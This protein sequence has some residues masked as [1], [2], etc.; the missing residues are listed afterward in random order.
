MAAS[1]QHH[2]VSR[3]LVAVGHPTKG[4]RTVSIHSRKYLR[5]EGDLVTLVTETT[6]HEVALGD[7]LAKQEAERPTDSGLLPIGCRYL[8]R[9]A[10]RRG[11]FVI[12]QAPMRRS[13]EY[14]SNRHDAPVVSHRLSLPYVVFVVSTVG[15]AIANLRTFFRTAPLA[16]LDDALSYS[17]LPNTYDDGTVC[18]GSVAVT[19]DSLA[20]R[21]DSLLAAYWSSRF[22]AEVRRHPLPF[23][24]GFRRWASMSRRDPTAGLSVSYDRYPWSLR[25]V[26]A[27]AAH[28]APEQLGGQPADAV[29]QATVDTPRPEAPAPEGGPSDAVAA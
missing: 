10:E 18:L 12:E 14:R 4:A 22:N 24:G 3:A 11:A 21:I 5:I 15:D 9:N 20:E 19:G 7:F 6:E 29:A 1:P 2:A 25:R 23:S 28:L 13:V 26:V 8:V 27:H 16:S 17:C